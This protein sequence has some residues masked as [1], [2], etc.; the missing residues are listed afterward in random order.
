MF[1]EMADDGLKPIP[2]SSPRFADIDQLMNVPEFLP[3][4]LICGSA[5]PV[6]II[7]PVGAGASEPK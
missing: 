6:R 2:S 7:R 5:R 1:L 3:S 4:L